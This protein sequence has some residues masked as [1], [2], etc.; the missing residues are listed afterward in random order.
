MPPKNAAF[1]RQTESHP[2]AAILASS[3]SLHRAKSLSMLPSGEIDA[4]ISAL[5]ESG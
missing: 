1:D 3:V 5:V 4:E 2:M